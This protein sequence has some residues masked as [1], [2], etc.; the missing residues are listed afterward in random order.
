MKTFTLRAARHRARVTQ[1]ALATKSGVHQTTISAIECG[2]MKRPSF[3]TVLKLA[4]ALEVDPMR[5]RFP[6]QPEAG[7]AA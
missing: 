3:D 1:E 7:A 2:R 4:A 6:V 5:L